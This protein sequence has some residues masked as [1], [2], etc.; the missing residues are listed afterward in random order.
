VKASIGGRPFLISPYRAEAF[1]IPREGQIADEQV[2]ANR[3]TVADAYRQAA[4]E[5]PGKHRNAHVHA[6]EWAERSD[7]KERIAELQAENARKATLSRLETILWLCDVIKTG[8]ANVDPKGPLCQK[9]LTIFPALTKL[10][11][12]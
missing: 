9:S 12:C 10:P 6:R 2:R 11:F 3:L 7:V 1:F 5:S 8:A 4:R